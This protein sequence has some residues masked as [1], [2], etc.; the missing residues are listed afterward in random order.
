MIH[1]HLLHYVRNNLQISSVDRRLSFVKEHRASMA[2][3]S[4]Y[5]ITGFNPFALE[6]PKLYAILA[7]LSAVGLKLLWSFSNSG[8]IFFKDFRSSRTHK[9]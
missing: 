6:R 4:A 8:P 2:S 1:F 5:F 9:N 3:T 7:F